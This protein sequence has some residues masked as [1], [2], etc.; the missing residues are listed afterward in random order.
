MFYPESFKSKVKAAFPDVKD[1]HDHLDNGNDEGVL[2]FLLTGTSL[3]ELL[4]VETIEE[5]KAI[6]EKISLYIDW[7]HLKKGTIV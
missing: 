4:N 6:H 1:L 5:C 2:E 3:T 7:W